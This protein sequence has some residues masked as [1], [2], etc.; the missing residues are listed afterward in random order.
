MQL[1]NRSF[2]ISLVNTIILF[3][4]TLFFINY[5]IVL[6]SILFDN[7]PFLLCAIIPIKSYSNA[8]TEKGKIIQ[9][10]KDKSGIYM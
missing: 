9:D 8:E 4:I 6:F 2:G 5:T 3:A 10:N 7:N 1:Y